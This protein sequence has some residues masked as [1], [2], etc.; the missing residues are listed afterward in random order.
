MPT[1]FALA[2]GAVK[3]LLK[4]F[5]GGHWWMR[6]PD[7]DQRANFATWVLGSGDTERCPGFAA[8]PNFPAGIVP[9][10]CVE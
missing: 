6:S 7:S 1:D 9:A 10:L 2:T 5:I 3:G 8:R 4:D